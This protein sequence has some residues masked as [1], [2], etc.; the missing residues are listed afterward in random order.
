MATDVRYWAVRANH[1]SYQ[2]DPVTSGGQTWL[3][4]ATEWIKAAVQDLQNGSTAGTG[5]TGFTRTVAGQ[6]AGLLPGSSGLNWES[7]ATPAKATSFDVLSSRSATPS[8][9][10]ATTATDWMAS[11]AAAEGTSGNPWDLNSTAT[12][13][14]APPSAGSNPWDL[15]STAT[16]GTTT[17][18]AGSNPWDLKSGTTTSAVPSGSN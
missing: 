16:A 7:S 6:W 3:E 17:P 13:E 8:Y 10:G 18:S 1:E 15:N 5:S 11:P 9:T 14:S 12:T 2:R 4:F